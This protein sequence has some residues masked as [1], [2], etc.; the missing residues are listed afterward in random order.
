MDQPIVPEFIALILDVL[1]AAGAARSQGIFRLAA[2]R[3]NVKFIQS[4]IQHAN[5]DVL[6]ATLDRPK[7]LTGPVESSFKVRDPN[8]AADLLK[9]TASAKNCCCWLRE[10]RD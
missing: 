6:Y 5:Y 2:D 4:Q 3:D 1:R 8:E 9:V 7:P 10:R